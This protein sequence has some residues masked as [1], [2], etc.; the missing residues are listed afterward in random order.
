[1]KRI[2]TITA[3]ILLIVAIALGIGCD[4]G[5]GVEIR[6]EGLNLGTVTMEGKPIAGLPSDKINLSIQVSAREVLVSTDSGVT[7][8]TLSP[9]EAT[10]EIKPSGVSIKGVKPEQ[11]KVEWATAKKD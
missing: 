3:S 9:S 1:M 2:I 5:G 11:V 10:I 4:I 7:T 8:L 6:L